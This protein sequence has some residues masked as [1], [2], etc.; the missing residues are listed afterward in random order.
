MIS[1]SRSIALE[2]EIADIIFNN[3]VC[4]QVPFI[5]NVIFYIRAELGIVRYL[6][7]DSFKCNRIFLLIETFNHDGQVFFEV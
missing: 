6:G 2:V 7:T 5:V 4:K 1:F 3:M